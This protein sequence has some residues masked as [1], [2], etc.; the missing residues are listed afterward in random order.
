VGQV[1]PLESVLEDM[2]LDLYN[3][4]GAYNKVLMSGN[5]GGTGE[6]ASCVTLYSRS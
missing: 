6:G 4:H 3:P 1:K 2:T 5:S